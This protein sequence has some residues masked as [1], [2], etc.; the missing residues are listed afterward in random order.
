MSGSPSDIYRRLLAG[1][2]ALLNSSGSARSCC[3]DP[4]ARMLLRLRAPNCNHGGRSAA[5][6]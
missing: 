1:S 5:A 2:A 6:E 3:C 4:G